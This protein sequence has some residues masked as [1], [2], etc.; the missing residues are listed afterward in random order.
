MR[1]LFVPACR[2]LPLSLC[3]IMAEDLSK[4]YPQRLMVHATRSVRERCQQTDGS[5]S[6]KIEAAL[7][8]AATDSPCSSRAAAAQTTSAINEAERWFSQKRKMTAWFSVS[9]HAD[10]SLNLIRLRIP[11]CQTNS[12]LHLFPDNHHGD[13]VFHKTPVMKP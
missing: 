3:E 2:R 7:K 9:V 4:A 1:F 13:Q 12:V 11:M 5:A 8:T 10:V 6:G